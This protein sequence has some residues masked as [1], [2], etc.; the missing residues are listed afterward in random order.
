MRLGLHRCWGI[1]SIQH[2]SPVQGLTTTTDLYP[3]FEADFELACVDW[4]MKRGS[5]TPCT[6]ISKSLPLI[7]IVLTRIHRGR[8]CFISVSADYARKVVGLLV[9]QVGAVARL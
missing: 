2:E 9:R 6:P 3:V 1:F 8:A 5:I 7:S 4:I